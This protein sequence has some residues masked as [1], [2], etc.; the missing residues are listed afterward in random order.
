MRRRNALR[1]LPAALLGAALASAAEKP[2]PDVRIVTLDG[3]ETAGTFAGVADGVWRLDAREEGIPAGRVLSVYFPFD[4]STATTA[5][6]IVT[7]ANGDRLRAVVSGAEQKKMSVDGREELRDFL[8]LETAFGGP[9]AVDLERI[10]SVV[11]PQRLAA[12]PPELREPLEEKLHA[13]DPNLRKDLVAVDLGG[14]AADMDDGAFIDPQILVAGAVAR[15]V[16]DP[17]NSG[18]MKTIQAPLVAARFKFPAAPPAPEGTTAVLHGRDGT[19][20]TGRLAGGTAEARTISLETVHGF[21]CAVPLSEIRQI[22]YRHPGLVFLSDLPDPDL[23]VRRFLADGEAAD[24][25][26][27]HFAKDHPAGPGGAVAALPL[28]LRG[29]LYE[30]GLG[31]HAYAR[32]G[33]ALDG[34]HT[35]FIA[36]VGIDDHVLEEAA[37]EAA[38]VICRVWGDGRLLYESPLLT[39]DAPPATVCVAIAGVRRL[40]LET[41]WGTRKDLETVLTDETTTREDLLRQTD[42]LDR[43]VWGHAVLVK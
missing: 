23:S 30:K 16:P 13:D 34:S 36:E 42:V 38:G 7:F 26:W 15:Q 10:R 32:L 31:T 39:A 40:E 12:L 14:G 19:R 37:P 20:L 4:P 24:L 18:A 27:R 28:R 17:D 25:L 33:Y 21:A 5:Q 8:A 43:A 3:A 1:I 22:D 6:P 9:F 11:H 2:P 29:R 35:R 41:D